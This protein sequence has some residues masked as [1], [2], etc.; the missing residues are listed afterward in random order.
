MPHLR[1]CLPRAGSRMQSLPS[2]GPGAGMRPV[3]TSPDLT[4]LPAPEQQQ[5]QPGDSGEQ[6]QQQQGQLLESHNRSLGS[7]GQWPPSASISE[8]W[9]IPFQE[10]VRKTPSICAESAAMMPRQ[11][12]R[13]ILCLINKDV[14]DLRPT[15]VSFC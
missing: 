15:P 2:P 7:L 1:A 9:I 10:L 4:H 8:G 12:K 13:V 14:D 5:Q 6:Q 11:T 3:L